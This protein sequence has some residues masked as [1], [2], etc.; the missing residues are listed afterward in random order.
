MLIGGIEI[1]DMDIHQEELTLDKAAVAILEVG[2]FGAKRFD[3]AALEH[4]AGF[5]LLEDLVVVMGFFVPGDDVDGHEK[6][7]CANYSTLAARTGVECH[8]NV[9]SLWQDKL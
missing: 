5:E 4:D 8:P 9:V 6:P 2:A 7:F 3:L 1:G